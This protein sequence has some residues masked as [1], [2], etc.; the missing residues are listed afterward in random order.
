MKGLYMEELEIKVKT[1]LDKDS[2][3]VCKK[4][5]SIKISKGFNYALAVLGLMIKDSS[6][7]LDHIDLVLEYKVRYVV[8]FVTKEMADKYIAELPKN[9]SLA[10]FCEVK[11]GKIFLED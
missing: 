10:L 4:I 1:L 9:E 2:Y 6:T 3:D 11:N 5:E 8:P 7:S